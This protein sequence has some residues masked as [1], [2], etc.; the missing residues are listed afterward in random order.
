[1]ASIS[2]VYF[3]HHPK[4][5]RW[6]PW[7]KI[8][9]VIFPVWKQHSNSLSLEFFLKNL[10]PLEALSLAVFFHPRRWG[11]N[12]I[13]HFYFSIPVSYNQKKISKSKN[14]NWILSQSIF[15][16]C[17]PR[18]EIKHH[19]SYQT[20]NHIDRSSFPLYI[21]QPDMSPSWFFLLSPLN[22]AVYIHCINIY[23]FLSKYFSLWVTKC[24]HP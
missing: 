13:L 24:R 5:Y 9:I 10:D 18:N 21:H 1:M 16:A 19:K 12:D 8:I 2:M 3:S 23:L 4:S 14:L 17:I 11:S 7:E 22:M 6:S 15:P 20:K